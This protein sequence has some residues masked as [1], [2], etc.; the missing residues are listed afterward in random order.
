[1]LDEGFEVDGLVQWDESEDCG[2][3]VAKTVIDG[4]EVDIHHWI[5]DDTAPHV[6]DTECGCGPVL[7]HEAQG[8][9]LFEHWDQ[10]DPA[11]SRLWKE[12]AA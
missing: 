8:V 6:P 9:V 5:P 12:P 4:A 1:V 10:D 7:R 2:C 11:V 3:W